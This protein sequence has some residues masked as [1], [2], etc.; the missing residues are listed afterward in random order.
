M[1]CLVNFMKLLVPLAL[2]EISKKKTYIQSAA[3]AIQKILSNLQKR[4]SVYDY[5]YTTRIVI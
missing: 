3:V 5:T 4:C 2:N 1:S